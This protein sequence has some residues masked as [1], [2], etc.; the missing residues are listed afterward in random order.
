[1]RIL[2]VLHRMH[3]NLRETHRAL[4]ES[5]IQCLYVVANIGPSEPVEFGGRVEMD[6]FACAHQ[7]IDDLVRDFAPSLLVQRNFDGNF[8]HF[9]RSARL[10]GAR[11]FRYSQ[12]PKF[13]PVP[14]LFFRPLR[15]ARMGRDFL[16]YRRVL[17][18]H[19]IVTPVARWGTRGSFAV[20][21]ACHVPLPMRPRSG[22]ASPEA[23]VIK[24]LTV[25]KHG[26]PEKRIRWLMSVVQEVSVPIELQVVGSSPRQDQPEWVELDSQLRVRGKHIE[27]EGLKIRFFD[28]LDEPELSEL[29][30]AADL[31]VLPGRR[32]HMAVSP[33]EAMA[34]GTPV[35][36][37]SE[38]GA[39][40]YVRQASAEQIFRA[41]SYRSFRE[42]TLALVSDSGRRNRLRA[43]NQRVIAKN[44][45]PEKFLAAVLNYVS[46]A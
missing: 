6:P 44:H 19:P 8:L 16:R 46:G 34:H 15:A 30:S 2:F 26:Q 4:T 13:F 18:K 38:N 1:M 3:P 33:L 31:F 12:D 20:P 45:S 24:L 11:T 41:G 22:G 40:D 37:S 42:R 5:G 32:E 9:W 27:R 7:E 17:G 39:A 29:Y 36:V 43:A 23:P 25:G 35:L 21:G 28:D 14:D 10:A